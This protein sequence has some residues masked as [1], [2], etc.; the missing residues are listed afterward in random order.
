MPPLSSQVKSSRMW[1]S[2]RRSTWGRFQPQVGSCFCTAA[3]RRSICLTPP[4]WGIPLE[5]LDENYLA[6]TSHVIGLPYGKNFIILTSTVF[7]GFTRVTDGRAIAYSALSIYAMLSRAKNWR[8]VE[9]WEERGEAG[10]CCCKVLITTTSLID[11]A[12][13]SP[14]NHSCTGLRTTK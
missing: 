12:L 6:K 2:R 3:T 9:E 8:R 4:L 14:L 11:S 5:F 10:E 7:V 1:P 13:P